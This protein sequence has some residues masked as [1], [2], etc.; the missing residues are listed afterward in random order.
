M[1]KAQQFIDKA[2]RYFDEKRFSDAIETYEKALEIEP[3]NVGVLIKIGLSYRHLENY[4]KAIEYYDR[5]LDIEPDNKVAINNIGWALQCKGEIERA[6][7]M[8]KKSLEIDQTYDIPLVNL[9]NI[10]FD[11]KEY[12][13]AV[14]TFQKALD[15]DHLNVANWIDLGRAYR[16]LE[17]YNKAISSYSEALDLDPANKI[18]WNNIGWAYFCAGDTDKAVDAYIESLKIDWLYDL[19]FVNLIKVYDEMRKIESTDIKG[20]KKIAYGFYIGKSY[21]RA[22]DAVNRAV[23]LDGDSDDLNRLKNKIIKAK[24]KLQSKDKL[25]SEIDKALQLFSQISNSV[26]IEEILNYIRFKNPDLDFKEQEIRFQ[27]YELI[28]KNRILA[29]INNDK[30]LFYNK[31]AAKVKPDYLK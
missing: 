17:Q 9:T 23:K 27:M 19:P 21:K 16:Y 31:P 3:K 6:E 13:K 26:L 22:L 15:K 24:L 30:L 25:N 20:W 2:K 14:E 28:Q 5:A 29:R 4:D 8:Y 7:E 11:K 12:Q 1:S 18:A 10:Y